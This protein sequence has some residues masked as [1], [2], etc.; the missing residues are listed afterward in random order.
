MRIFILWALIFVLQALRNQRGISQI[1][2]WMQEQVKKQE[3]YLLE[4]GLEEEKGPVLTILGKPNVGKSSLCNF[5]LKKKHRIV[6]DIPGTTT[7]SV[8]TSVKVADKSYRIT[9]T[10][11]LRRKSKVQDVLEYLSGIQARKKIPAG[12]IALV[13]VDGLEGVTDQDAKIFEVVEKQV[14][15]CILVVN[16]IDVAGKKEAF[17][18]NFRK[19]VKKVFHF[20]SQLPVVFISAHTGSGI[21]KLFETIDELY[22]K[23]RLRIPTQSLNHFF[24][25]V[26]QRAPS[27][28]SGKK[29][30]KVYYA[31]QT[32]Q[33][34]PSF[35]VFVNHPHLAKTSYRRF[36]VN[37]IKKNWG[38]ESIPVRVYLKKK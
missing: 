26:M 34:P 7:D 13:M 33:V 5:L 22:A 30:L 31:T 35:M 29:F 37:Q 16:K 14:K 38:L 21:K 27:A 32:Q 2:E 3:G 15:P 17:R 12:D 25:S 6:S 24:T 11:G 10:A 4:E 1:S 28:S 20:S 18:E 19:Q 23:S 36:L 9:D 8:T